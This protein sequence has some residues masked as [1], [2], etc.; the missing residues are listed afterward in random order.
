LPIGK[1]KKLIG[2]ITGLLGLTLQDGQCVY[3]TAL[4]Q[5]EI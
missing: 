3:R 5:L 2:S 4:V 1:L